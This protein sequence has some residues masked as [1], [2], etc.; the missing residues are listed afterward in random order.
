MKDS[1]TA[2]ERMLFLLTSDRQTEMKRVK[3][4]L[5]KHEAALQW[6]I[7]QERFGIDDFMKANPGYVVSMRQSFF[8]Y[9]SKLDLCKRVDQLK[10]TRRFI[11]EVDQEAAKVIAAW[12]DKRKA[13]LIAVEKIGKGETDIVEQLNDNL[14]AAGYTN[15]SV[16]EFKVA[17]KNGD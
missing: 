12:F 15:I 6:I 14:K 7:K 2:A 10:G 17:E 9:M 3:N 13:G 11:F 8:S 1:K 4:L 5:E 16:E